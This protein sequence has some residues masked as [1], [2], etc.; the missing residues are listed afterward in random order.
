MIEGFNNWLII[1]KGGKEKR[2]ICCMMNF[3]E[4][5]QWKQFNKI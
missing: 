5:T 3:I 2:S 1:F 4:Y